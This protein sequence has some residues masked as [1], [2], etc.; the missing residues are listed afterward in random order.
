M[1]LFDINN[2]NK[3]IIKEKIN[4][5]INENNIENNFYQ[6]R[7]IFI[8]IDDLELE[9][10]KDELSKSN[11]YKIN[12]SFKL[13][14]GG[15]ATTFIKHIIPINPVSSTKTKFIKITQ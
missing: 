8:K 15:Y 4:L 5:I 13:R 9:I 12:L 6:N 11:R 10:L 3:R 14:S 2:Q 7:E 1:I